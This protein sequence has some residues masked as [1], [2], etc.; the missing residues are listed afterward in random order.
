LREFKATHTD[1]GG[2]ALECAQSRNPQKN[3]FTALVDT[4]RHC[5]LGEI[6]TRCSRS[7]AG[8]AAICAI[9]PATRRRE[10]AFP[11]RD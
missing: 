11:G 9:R 10:I 8:S 5:S 3:I 4:V 6:T 7:A 1:T 2:A